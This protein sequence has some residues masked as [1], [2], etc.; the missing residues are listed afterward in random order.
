MPISF[1]KKKGDKSDLNNE[2]GV[3]N[4]V[5]L[6][7]ILDK[8]ILNDIYDTIDYEMSPSN[9]GGR[10]GRNIRDHLF[11]VNGILN[12]VTENKEECA[13]ICIYDVAKCFD[14]MNY[15]ETSNDIYNANIKDDK[16]LLLTESNKESKVA[17]KTSWGSVTKRVELKDLEM[18]G[19]VIAPLKCSLQVDLIGKFCLR[20][21][22]GVYKYKGCLSL[23][24]LSM[25]DDIISV[26]K[27]GAETIDSNG[28]IA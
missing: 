4:V 25:I 6:R 14:K 26:T 18:Q 16:F 12:D 17:V 19:T 9:I 3:F 20:E 24:P 27:C 22:R 21:G 2:R 5:K 28:L 7:S 11:V 15:K 13:D 10:K 1:Y 23:P 8:L